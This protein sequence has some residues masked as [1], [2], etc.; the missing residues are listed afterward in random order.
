MIESTSEHSINDYAHPSWCDLSRCQPHYAYEP[1]PGG[2]HQS[3]GTLWQI[4]SDEV[5]FIARI[6]RDDDF[7][8]G[9]GR[10]VGKT[11]LEIVLRNNASCPPGGGDTDEYFV[12]AGVDPEDA[13]MLATVL[14][15]YAD[16]A[17][18]AERFPV[19]LKAT[20]LAPRTRR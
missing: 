8:P 7:E 6:V 16:M 13:R 15:R 18:R 12:D 3:A 10:Q 11:R 19:D 20:E 4:Q 9:T 5:D 2:Y 17:E 1:R 14:T